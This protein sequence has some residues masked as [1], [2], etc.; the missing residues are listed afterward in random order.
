MKEKIKSFVR[1]TLKKRSYNRAHSIYIRFYKE[2]IEA[3]QCF[4]KSVEG[5]KEWLAH[6]RK[7]DRKLKP[8]SYRIFSYFMGKGKKIIPPELISSIIEPILT[9]EKYREYY[10]DKN[11]FLRI[12]PSSFLPEYFLMDIDGLVYDSN[13]DIVEK[14]NIDKVIRELRNRFDKIV[15]K[16]SRTSSGKGVQ[17]IKKNDAGMFV[18]KNNIPFS[19]AFIK[20]VYK[21][22]W[23]LQECIN[24]SDYMA[25]FNPTSINTI[26]IAV[27]RN[28]NGDL[29]CL[30]AALRIG[31]VGSEVDNAHAGGKFCGILPNGKIGNY[32]CDVLGKREFS[33]NNLDFEKIFEYANKIGNIKPIK[34][35]YEL[36]GKNE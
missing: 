9:P 8:L 5:E 12:L 21:T 16:P 14:E 20:E 33:F 26:R 36:G 17:I 3:N 30:S 34:K 4:A 28:E 31:A 11:N 7:Y 27:Y 32:V 23:C 18:T 10:S 15:I 22:N 25:N 35:L 19:Y 6:W 24:Q 1:R 13:Y 29:R 2:I